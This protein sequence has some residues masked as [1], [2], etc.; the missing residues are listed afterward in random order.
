[1]CSGS[2]ITRKLQP[3]W[4]G[5]CLCTEGKVA[6]NVFLLK[7]KAKI[8]ST[9]AAVNSFGGLGRIFCSPRGQDM[10]F[11]PVDQCYEDTYIQKSVINLFLFL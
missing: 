2:S 3:P 10:Y 11:L 8:I 1:M 9:T 5:V 6:G 4:L 7:I